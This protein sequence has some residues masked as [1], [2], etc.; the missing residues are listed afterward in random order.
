[1]TSSA[2]AWRHLAHLAKT[3][4]DVGNTVNLLTQPHQTMLSLDRRCAPL[5]CD[6][7]TR[8]IEWHPTEMFDSQARANR[9][10][11]KDPTILVTML[12]HLGF[13]S[14]THIQD[15][16]SHFSV[17]L[18]ITKRHFDFVEDNS[19]ASASIEVFRF[20][21]SFQISIDYESFGWMFSGVPNRN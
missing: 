2:S 4:S 3:L 15:D 11:V 1:M 17:A 19:M 8:P 20:G 5:E 12:S 6:D 21:F 9:Y 14:W 18:T 13:S 16:K 7:P 10:T